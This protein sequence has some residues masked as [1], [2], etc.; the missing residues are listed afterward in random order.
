MAPLVRWPSLTGR[1][2]LK[3]LE[4]CLNVILW[5]HFREPLRRGGVGRFPSELLCQSD[6]ASPQHLD[7]LLP[8]G[9]LVSG[10]V[11]VCCVYGLPRD[12][13]ARILHH[14]GNPNR[15]WPGFPEGDAANS[16]TGSWVN[17]FISFPHVQK[18]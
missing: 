13:S 12:L 4:V 18:R 2:P 7:L 17:G 15:R 8:R 9:G 14:C 16:R 1:G 5:S 3:N 11:H 10:L 6:Q